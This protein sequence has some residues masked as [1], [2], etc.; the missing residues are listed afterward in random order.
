MH[1]K[2]DHLCHIPIL[3]PPR[4]TVHATPH[5][6]LRNR[7]SNLAHQIEYFSIPYIPSL[8]INSPKK[9]EAKLGLEKPPIYHIQVDQSVLLWLVALSSFIRAQGEISHVTCG[10]KCLTRKEFSGILCSFNIKM[11]P[12]FPLNSYYCN[13]LHSSLSQQLCSCFSCFL[14]LSRLSWELVSNRIRCNFKTD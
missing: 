12:I 2:N 14:V 9:M 6:L 8:S 4:R 13:I 3:A 10:Y 11:P 1:R 5:K 7:V